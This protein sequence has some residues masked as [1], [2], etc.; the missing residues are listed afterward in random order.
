MELLKSYT[1]DNFNFETF[2]QSSNPYILTN[3]N[4]KPIDKYFVIRKLS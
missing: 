4:R 1:P 2:I 3:P